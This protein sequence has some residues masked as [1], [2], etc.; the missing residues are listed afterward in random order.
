[1]TQKYTQ[2]FDFKQFEANAINQLRLGQ[3][4]TGAEGV[5]TPLIKRIIEASLEGEIEHHLS[6]CEQYHHPNRRNGK[7]SKRFKRLMVQWLLKRLE[8]GAVH[9]SRKWLKSV[10]RF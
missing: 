2:H 8:I 1:M 6:E 5:L 9:L 7:L 3:P 4:L 10:K